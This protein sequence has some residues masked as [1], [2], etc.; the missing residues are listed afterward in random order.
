MLLFF[1]L[2]L[3]LWNLVWILH[4]LHFAIQMLNFKQLKMKSNPKKINIV[5]N[6]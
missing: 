2:A 1:F 3:S 5:F 6:K 4:L